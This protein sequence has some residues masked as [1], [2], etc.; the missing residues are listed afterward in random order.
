MISRK[1]L[2]LSLLMIFMLERMIKFLWSY[3]VIDV[4]CIY[5]Q[6]KWRL[7]FLMAII[8]CWSA[9]NV[10]L[11]KSR[12]DPKAK[13]WLLILVELNLLNWGCVRSYIWS[14]KINFNI[15]TLTSSVD[16]LKLISE[17]WPMRNDLDILGF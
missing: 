17:I 1:L 12:N 9:K 10:I 14:I 4:S 5:A 15:L 13:N 3:L 6:R 8:W 11:M 16:A 2:C 7:A